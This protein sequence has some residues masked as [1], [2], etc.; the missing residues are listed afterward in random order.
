M[1][2]PQRQEQSFVPASL[3]SENTA[4]FEAIM[5]PAWLDKIK[6]RTPRDFTGFELV[7]LVPMFLD[8]SELNTESL[9]HLCFQFGVDFDSDIQ[10]TVAVLKSAIDT[11][12]RKGTPWSVKNVLSAF[13]FRRVS[14]HEGRVNFM[15]NGIEQLDGIE[16][17]VSI[18]LLLD[19]GVD[20]WAEFDVRLV[21]DNNVVSED[22]WLKIFRSIDSYK[23]ARSILTTTVLEV[24]LL[25]GETVPTQ[26]AYNSKVSALE[27]AQ[28]KKIRMRFKNPSTSQ[29]FD[30]VVDVI[31]AGIDVK[32]LGYDYRVSCKFAPT[33]ASLLFGNQKCVLDSVRFL[34]DEPVLPNQAQPIDVNYIFD[35]QIS[36]L[37]PVTFEMNLNYTLK[38]GTG[39]SINEVS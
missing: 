25:L 8:K 15:L 39:I 14:I 5:N 32:N 6:N 20:N 36:Y 31:G 13:G 26:A 29:E 34:T 1:S 24:S 21:W 19:G 7:N 27:S 23:N 16:N 10:K 35:K 12:K 18:P 30:F 2:I 22:V 11:M 33:Q 38:V 17:A 4:G 37:S 9:R 28:P 3:W